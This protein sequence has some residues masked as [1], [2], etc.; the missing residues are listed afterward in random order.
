MNYYIHDIEI[1][2]AVKPESF[3]SWSFSEEIY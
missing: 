3:A 2:L 1:T